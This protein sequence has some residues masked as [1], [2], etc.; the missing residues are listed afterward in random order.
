MAQN[1]LRYRRAM[2]DDQA[3]TDADLIGSAE[4]CEIL[5]GID[6]GT[7]VRR[8]AAGK[9]TAV[10]KLPGMRGPYVF[11]RSEI[12]RA[13]AEDKDKATASP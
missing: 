11:E 10:H 4:A 3:M 6:R 8:V 9:I 13:A 2:H 5:G 12:L 7:L 1:H